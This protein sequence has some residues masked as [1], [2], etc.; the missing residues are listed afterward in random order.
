MDARDQAASPL[1]WVGNAA[2]REQT[3]L[4]FTPNNERP[5][6]KWRR[7]A[8]ARAICRRCPVRTPCREWARMNGEYGFWGGESEEERATAGFAGELPVGRVARILRDRR[9]GAG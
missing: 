5:R 3:A 1:W 2:C 7:E 6:A 8:Q 9:A 4:F